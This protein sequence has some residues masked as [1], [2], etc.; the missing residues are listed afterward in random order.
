[1][2]LRGH[3]FVSMD[4]LSP[5]EVLRVLDTATDLKRRA[6]AG[7]RPVLLAGRVL[8]MIFEKPSLR[9]RVT[10]EVGM[11]EL[12]GH[13]VYLA[14]QDVQL[15]ARE[16]V[17]DVARNL[18]RWV[19]GIMARTFAHRTVQTLAEHARIPVINGLSDLEHPCQTLGDLLTI[20]ERFGHLDGLRVAWVGDGN[21]VCHSLLLGAAKV[22][23]HVAVATPARYAPDPA[24]VARAREIAPASGS[25]IE[26]G[27]D[28]K[29]A[30]RGADVIYTDVWVSMGQEAEREA[31]IKVFSGYQVNGALTAQAA[32]RAVVMHC[33]PAHRGEEITS[34]VLDGPQSIVF[35]QA[36]NRLHAQKAL[37]SLIL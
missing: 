27:T 33:L 6:K 12:G 14:P 24:I 36:E 9:T 8:A 22:G 7:D 32:A 2:M 20:R 17:P 10:F 3:D 34:E 26:V 19:G 35:E 23:M 1:M 28:A 30:A 18:E 11:W 16:S 4:D 15:G 13:A 25:R 29:A 5:E 21:N 37:L 31:K